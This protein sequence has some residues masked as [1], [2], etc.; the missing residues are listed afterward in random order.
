M[1]KYT[2]LNK[3]VENRLIKLAKDKDE[4]D[5]ARVTVEDVMKSKTIDYR[6]EQIEVLKAS[7][8]KYVARINGDPTGAPMEDAAEAEKAAK[9]FI[10]RS[11]DKKGAK[12]P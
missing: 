2:T 6:G 10:D 9:Q 3:S 12:K 8:G 4:H 1:D 11:K 7:S 5:K